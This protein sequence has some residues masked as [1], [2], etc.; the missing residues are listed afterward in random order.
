ERAVRALP[1]ELDGAGRL[2]GS[3]LCDFHR[4]VFESL[5]H[6]HDHPLLVAGGRYL[7]R[8]GCRLDETRDRQAGPPLFLVEIEVDAGEVRA[9]NGGDDLREDLEERAPGLAG[10]D[11]PQRLT[12]R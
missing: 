1:V 7:E 5:G 3:S 4:L 8:L 11:G 2:E 10:E 9:V 6:G 12:L